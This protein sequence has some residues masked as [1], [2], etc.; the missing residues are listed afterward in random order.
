MMTG[1]CGGTTTT[2]GGSGGSSGSGGGSGT[3]GSG[4]GGSSGSGIVTSRGSGTPSTDSVSYT[5]TLPDSTGWF[6]P[7]LLTV[8]GRPTRINTTSLNPDPD[9]FTIYQADSTATNLP[10]ILMFPGTENTTATIVDYMG[11]QDAIATRLASTE[12]A[13]VIAIPNTRQSADWDHSSAGL[14]F[15]TTTDDTD[16]NT[17]ILLVRAV[18]KEAI[19][20]YGIDPTRVYTMGFSNG[21]FFSAFT[22]FTI[23][24]R[25]AGFAERSGGWAKCLPGGSK[26]D[27]PFTSSNSNCNT[28]SSTTSCTCDMILSEASGN[29]NYTC[30]SSPAQPFSALTTGTN[31]VPGY[32]SHDPQ[33][34]SVSVYYSC[35]L[36][37][38]MS[39]AGFTVASPDLRYLADDNGGRHGVATGFFN[40]A[41]D[42]LR[43]K[44]L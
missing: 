29:S 21:A 25:I 6:T 28:I 15:D 38:S 26:F 8:S 16:T 22:A 39:D 44:G 30:T 37:K 7:S 1:G 20:V 10:L 42:F 5:G 41:W 9:T 14:F 13:I 3:G 32:I 27:P 19:R 34:N 11:G 40:N 31:R 36:Y 18:I 4:T 33:D 23:P 24:T 2:S 17:D 43:T 35:D 12:Q